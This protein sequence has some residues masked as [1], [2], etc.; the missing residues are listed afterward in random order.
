MSGPVFT[1]EV[2]GISVSVVGTPVK[3]AIDSHPHH[4]FS[5]YLVGWH[6]E[7]RIIVNCPEDS[8]IYAYQLMRHLPSLTRLT[9]PRVKVEGV[10][11]IDPVAMPTLYLETGA[12][13][14][15]NVYPFI[16]CTEERR[17]AS[18]QQFRCNAELACLTNRHISSHSDLIVS[19]WCV[20]RKG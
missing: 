7:E 2:P 13:L 11:T 14:E 1:E 19:R 8:K 9:N 18:Q 6:D 3:L 17:E 16:N 15:N 4:P 20:K 10:T 5:P 12:F